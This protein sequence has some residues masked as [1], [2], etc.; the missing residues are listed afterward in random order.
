MLKPLRLFWILTLVGCITKASNEHSA[1]STPDTT[2]IEHFNI[3]IAPDLSNRQNYKLYPRPL[4]DGDI[5]STLMEKFP[6]ILNHRRQ[7]NQQD[8]LSI[9]FINKNW[10]E[11][12]QINE[13]Q[14]IIDFSRF[15]NQKKR[16]DYL[17]GRSKEKF[18]TD[19]ARFMAEY[20]KIDKLARNG[21]SGSDIWSFLNSG[22]DDT[23][24]KT[25]T[26]V[27]T[28]LGKMYKNSFRNILII[29]TDGYIEADMYGKDACLST[30]PRQCYYLSTSRIKQFRNAHKYSAASSIDE[31]FKTS[32]WGIAK[33]N[34]DLL[35]D[36]EV[37]ILEIYD[38]SLTSGGTATV[39][40]SD[41][42]IIRLFWSDW[43]RKSGVT[44]FDIRPVADTKTEIAEVVLKFLGIE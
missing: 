22:V 21:T 35:K 15:E 32:G 28:F 7:E 11:S 31:F 16:I 12:A 34:N 14:L 9:A 19:T 5:I 8:K 33:A 38:R 24:I 25:E 37:L 13:E 23:M 20:R 41:S 2:G 4:K 6:A 1:Q 44:R 18:E 27:E 17:K 30:N 43:L 10:T 40:P 26:K 29:L 36:T 42:E 39:H 3:I